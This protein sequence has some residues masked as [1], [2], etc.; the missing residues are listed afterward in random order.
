MIDAIS[1]LHDHEFLYLDLKPANIYLHYDGTAFLLDFGAARHTLQ[2]NRKKLSWVYTKG[3]A[4]P[5]LLHKRRAWMGPW[6]DAYSVGATIFACMAGYPPQEADQRLTNDRMPQAFKALRKLY[7]S[8]LLD[9]VEWCLELERERRPQTMAVL[10]QRLLACRLTHP[11]R[12][13][14]RIV[15]RLSD[16]FREATHSA[17]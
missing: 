13:K 3:Y 9:L 16:W 11:S 5:E 1:T 6:T 10:Q 8:D 12:P 15:R 14:R 4:A 17:E 2:A 7:S